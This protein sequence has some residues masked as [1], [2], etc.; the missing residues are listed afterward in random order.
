MSSLRDVCYNKSIEEAL[1]LFSAS[2]IFMK[3]FPSFNPLDETFFKVN[4]YFKYIWSIHLQIDNNIIPLMIRRIQD[5]GI[6]THD[7]DEDRWIAFAE[8]ICNISNLNLLPILENLNPLPV[9]LKLASK[10]LTRVPTLQ[11]M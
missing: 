9:N 11:I 7:T 8:D 4:S 1:S 10:R 3:F 6:R 5:P 2:I